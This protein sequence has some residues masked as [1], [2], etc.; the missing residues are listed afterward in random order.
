MPRWSRECA[1]ALLGSPGAGA[2]RATHVRTREDGDVCQRSQVLASGGHCSSQQ[3]L[4]AARLS[5]GGTARGQEAG[6]A[7]GWVAARLGEATRAGHTAPESRD[8]GAVARARPPALAALAAAAHWQPGP[9]AAPPEGPGAGAQ[10]PRAPPGVHCGWI[11]ALQA[12]DPQPWVLVV[13]LASLCC[14]PPTTPPRQAAADR[15]SSHTRGGRNIEVSWP[16][17][18]GFSATVSGV[19]TVAWGS[20]TK[21]CC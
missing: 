5:A 21:S 16:F 18:V 1:Q 7:G 8:A 12:E 15:R 4:L 10:W 3:R 2:S 14:P 9:A 20:G 11:A 6:L 19:L 13:P 17:L